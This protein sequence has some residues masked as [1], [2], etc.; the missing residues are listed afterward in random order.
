MSEVCFFSSRIRLSLLVAS[1]VIV[2][3]FQYFFLQIV[4][5]GILKH[6]TA[7]MG[8]VNEDRISYRCCKLIENLARYPNL[9]SMLISNKVCDLLVPIL[10]GSPSLGTQLAAVR[11]LRYNQAYINST[12]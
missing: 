7:I 11:S 10:N 1:K 4:S 2:H 6:L 5:D 12:H 9:C 8:C 3:H